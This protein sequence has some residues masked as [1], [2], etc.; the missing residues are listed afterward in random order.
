MGKAYLTVSP[1]PRPWSIV[2]SG[3]AWWYAEVDK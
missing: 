1:R 2:D 3:R